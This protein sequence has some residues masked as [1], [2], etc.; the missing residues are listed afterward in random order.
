MQVLGGMTSSDLTAL[1]AT[2]GAT[3]GII[4]APRGAVMFGLGAAYLDDV[5]ATTDT[6]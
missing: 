1:Q 2:A 4:P 3:G 6:S 5:A